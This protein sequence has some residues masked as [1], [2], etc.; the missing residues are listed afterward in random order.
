M[1]NIPNLYDANRYTGISL[2]LLV[3][4]G[5]QQIYSVES[6]ENTEEGG[7]NAQRFLRLLSR[8]LFPKIKNSPIYL[9]FV[10]FGLPVQ[11]FYIKIRYTSNIGT[12]HE[13]TV[14]AILVLMVTIYSFHKRNL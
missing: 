7:G 1:F 8:I 10:T 2:A 12:L 4:M 13:S 9:F 5:I 3:L 6:N 14:I 11:S